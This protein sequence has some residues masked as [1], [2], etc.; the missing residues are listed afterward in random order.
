MGIH[1]SLHFERSGLSKIVKHQT[2]YISSAIQRAVIEV[3][4]QGTEAAAASGKNNS[5][6]NSEMKD[7]S[8]IF[9]IYIKFYITTIVVINV[10]KKETKTNQTK[11][12]SRIDNTS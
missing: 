3:T 7:T 6:L 2:I 12:L 11:S 4:E 1:S 10:V 8:T 9:A 5:N